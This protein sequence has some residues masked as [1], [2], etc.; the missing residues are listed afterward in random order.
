MEDE[1]ELKRLLAWNALSDL[2]VEIRRDRT[3]N[4]DGTEGVYIQNGWYPTPD[5]E[6][7]AAMIADVRPNSSSRS[8]EATARLWRG[9]TPCSA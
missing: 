4:P 7:Y 5:A 2:F 9:K 3:V 6:T 1:R 8:V